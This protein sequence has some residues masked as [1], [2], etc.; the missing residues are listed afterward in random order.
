MPA[1]SQPLWKKEISRILLDSMP[2]GVMM[3][4][5]QQKVTF[6]NHQ[7]AHIFDIPVTKNLNSQVDDFIKCLNLSGGFGVCDSKNN[8]K[9]C[10][11]MKPSIKA[12]K[13]IHKSSAQIVLKN[14][15]RTIRKDLLVTSVPVKHEDDHHVLVLVEDISEI[16]YLR[17]QLRDNS[18]NMGIW[19]EDLQIIAL[20]KKIRSLAHAKFPVLISGESG[21]GK[22][23]VARA[24]HNQG[25][26]HNKPFIPV[27]CG[28]I[29]DSLLESELFGHVKGAFTGATQDRKGRF[30]LAHGGTL[31]LDEIGDIS[32]SMQVKLLRVIQEGT[33]DRLGDERPQQTD[34]RIICATNKD[35][36]K[37]IELG[38]FREDLF[39]RVCVYPLMVP[40]LRDRKDDI[41]II[42][43][44]LVNSLSASLNN[45]RFCIANDAMQCLMEYK[46]PGN[47]RELENALKYAI[48]NSPG[49]EIKPVHLPSHISAHCDVIMNSR[50][51]SRKRKLDKTVVLEML[52]KVSWNKMAAAKELGVSRATLYRFLEFVGIDR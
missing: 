6:A 5:K 28:A 35:L 10:S 13:R 31:F 14:G 16:A 44:Y 7:M 33:F 1:S 23:L 30:A 17:Q 52:D 41:P 9:I 50:K 25:Y 40:P 21:T 46:W 39:Y 48:V 29:P 47:I 51:R 43:K 36:K 11:L 4:N 8:C 15:D 34:V 26:G 32:P 24:I 42:S 20:C 18:D 38:N 3:I 45:E 19:G 2:T 22:E 37:E 49:N 12:L 27:N